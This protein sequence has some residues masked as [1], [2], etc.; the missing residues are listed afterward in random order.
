MMM[1]DFTDRQEH[2]EP[3]EKMRRGRVQGVL[4]T[5]L[6]L[7]FSVICAGPGLGQSAPTRSAGARSQA[8]L[9]NED[10]VKLIKLDLG[11]A[12]VIAKINQAEAIA[13]K[14]ETDDLVKLKGQGV[15]K[16]VIAAMLKRA[17][18][19]Q[20]GTQQGSQASA[21]ATAPGSGPQ[22]TTASHVGSD[23]RLITDSGETLLKTTIGDI[24]IV[25]FAFVKMAYYEIPGISSRVRISDKSVRIAISADFPPEG[26]FFVLQLG[27]DKKHNNRSMKLGSASQGSF[28]TRGQGKP[29]MDSAVPCKVEKVSD[30]EWRL[31]PESPLTPGEYGV[32]AAALAQGVQGLYDFGVD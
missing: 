17:T 26:Y 31:V 10:V 29:D 16:E 15:H 3:G 1:G 32:W 2:P 28:R 24:N 27:I 6:V 25:G 8:A 18:V 12:V 5:L 7:A 14:L 22:T 19:P 4:L 21:A 9:T 11:D 20:Q 30:N 23:I 13:F